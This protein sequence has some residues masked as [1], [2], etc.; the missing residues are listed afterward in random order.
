LRIGERRNLIGYG[1]LGF[2]HEWLRLRH[3]FAP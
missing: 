2:G 3:K 1:L